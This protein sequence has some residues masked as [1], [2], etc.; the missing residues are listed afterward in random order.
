MNPTDVNGTV[1]EQ[2]PTGELRFVDGK[3]EQL[4]RNVLTGETVWKIV[5]AFNTKEKHHGR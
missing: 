5:P 3:L 2:T 4:W 1:T